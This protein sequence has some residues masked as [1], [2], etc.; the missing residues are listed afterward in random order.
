MRDSTALP[1]RCVVIGPRSYLVT[2]TWPSCL[3]CPEDSPL[4]WRAK[5]DWNTIRRTRSLTFGEVDAVKLERLYPPGKY[6]PEARLLEE[7]TLASK[8]HAAGIEH[9]QELMVGART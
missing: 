3:P 1:T 2:A 8:L 4:G 5:A 6:L 7:L 9:L